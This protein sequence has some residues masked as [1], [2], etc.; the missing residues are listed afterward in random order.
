[1]AVSTIKHDG[2]GNP[3]RAKYRIVALGNLDSNNWSRS[4]TYAP[5]MNLIELRLLTS[6]AIHHR[7]ILKSGDFKQAFCQA[8]LPPNEMYVLRPPPGCPFTPPNSYWLLK[9]T[10]YG[11]KRSP[12]HWF[13]RA[14]QLLGE[15]G[16]KPLQNSPCIFKGTVIDGKAPLFLGLYVD[17]FV[18]FSEDP[19]VEAEFESKLK[20]KTLVDFMGTVTHFL[21]IKFQWKHFKSKNQRHL[22]VHLSQSAYVEHL[23]Q[24]AGLC[25]ESANYKP[26]PYRSGLPVDN[27]EYDKYNTEIEKSKI[28]SLLRSLVG[29]LLWLS[30]GTRPDLSTIVAFLAA[31]QNKASIGHI[32]AARHAIQYLQGTK[33]LG[34]VFNSETPT[35]IHSFLQKPQDPFLALTDANW[36]AQDQIR[37]PKPKQIELFKSRSM[38]GHIVFLYGPIQWQSKRQTVTARSSVEA[39]IYATDECVREL[40]YLRKVIRDLN[41]EKQIIKNP[42]PIFNDNMACVQWSK[43]KTTRSIRHIQLRDNGVREEV[44]KG[45]VNIYHIK[46]ADNLADIFTKEDKDPNHFKEIRNR[47]LYKPFTSN[48]VKMLAQKQFFKYF[49]II[50]LTAIP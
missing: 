49:T 20:A 30:Q 33:S 19:T 47:I 46:G 42:I 14:T 18:Y 9:R 2:D 8:T 44:Q 24:L 37:N 25:Q 36:G 26:T 29:S 34:I 50:S 6:I 10:L 28:Q 13:D 4:D 21:G 39:E 41:M 43:N 40:I 12:R 23:V 15:I 16:L 31:F 5:V 22:K 38:S 11:L 1:M 48:R 3:K 27:V 17:D 45:R 7:R 32:Q 35:H